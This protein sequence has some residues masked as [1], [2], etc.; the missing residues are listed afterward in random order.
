VVIAGILLFIA[1]IFTPAFFLASVGTGCLATGLATLL[2]NL[3]FKGQLVSLCVATMV[4][5]SP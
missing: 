4:S 5:R 1:E 2:F 3:G